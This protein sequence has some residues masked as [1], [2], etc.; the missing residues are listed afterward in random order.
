MEKTLGMAWYKFLIYFALI[1]G[2][3]SN[4]IYA[5]L[6]ISGKIYALQTN[7]WVTAEDVYEYYGTDL[8]T[9]NV[10]YGLLLITIAIVAI[11]ARQ[12][13]AK[14]RSDSL[15]FIIILYS[16][17][18]AVPVLYAFIGA[19][20][21]EQPIDV[22]PMISAIVGFLFLFFNVI[23][24]NKRAHLFVDMPAWVQQ[25]IQSHQTAHTTSEIPVV[26]KPT[27]SEN[28]TVM[29]CRKCGT[30]LYED[31]T[32]CHCCGTKTPD[33]REISFCRKCG[34][35]L[36]P[37]SQYCNKCGTLIYTGGIGHDVQ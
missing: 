30:K 24:F 25:P 2:A 22:Q 9:I 11:I 34:E 4:I 28:A 23:Y 15:K 35:R 29:F 3:V 10:L 6:Y 13:L 12:K 36:P 17:N 19:A 26:S 14:F 33:T 7:G 32:F 21:T 27:G 8:Q 20:I 1:A 37:N 31:S 18:A 16:L 5:L